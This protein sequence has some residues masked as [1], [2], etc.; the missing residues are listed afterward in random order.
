MLLIACS[1]IASLLVARGASRRREL[2]VRAALGAGRG[3]LLWELATENILLSLAGGLAGLL[4]ADAGLHVLLTRV[5][6]D[7][8]RSDAIT[9]N[10]TVLAFTFGLCLI[11]GML[12]GLFPALQIAGKDPQAGLH[13]G[14]Q[15]AS[16]GPGGDRARGWLIASQFALAIVLLTGAGL[17][18]RASSYSILSDL[19]S[20]QHIY[21]P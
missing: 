9:I 20:T 5:P 2:A 6:A 8:P 10:G 4:L 21:S 14:G 19:D 18:I 16:A 3:R 17:L 13:E 12:F 15:S 11:T 7:L 1:N